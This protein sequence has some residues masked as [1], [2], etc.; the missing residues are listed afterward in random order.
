MK[1]GIFSSNFRIFKFFDKKEIGTIP[2]IFLSSLI[3]ILFFYSMPTLVNYTNNDNRVFQNNSKKAIDD[4]I[5]REK[6]V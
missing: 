4:F 6:Y 3:L 5:N 1:K 2:R